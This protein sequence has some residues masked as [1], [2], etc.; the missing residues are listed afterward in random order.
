MAQ[1]RKVRRERA[2]QA[3]ER[4]GLADR[5]THRP[6]E[7]SGGQCQRV[8]IARALANGPSLLL[9]DEPTGNLDSS[10]GEEIMILFD[11]LHEEGNTV[12]LV[13]HDPVIAPTGRADDP[14]PRRSHRF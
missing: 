4:V 7:L 2:M 9:A 10:T 11:A 5:M 12:L 1:R 6:A 14:H 8:A 3:L 13:T